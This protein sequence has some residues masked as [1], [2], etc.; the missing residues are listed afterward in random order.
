[1]KSVTIFIT[2][3]EGEFADTLELGTVDLEPQL[4]IMAGIW[5]IADSQC[6]SLARQII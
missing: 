3:F 4:C 6:E 1:M 2:Y 5:S